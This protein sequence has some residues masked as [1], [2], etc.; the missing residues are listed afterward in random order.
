[1]VVR[2]SKFIPV[3][4]HHV[5]KKSNTF[6]KVCNTFSVFTTQSP[7]FYHNFIH[8]VFYIFFLMLHKFVLVFQDFL[9]NYKKL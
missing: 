6:Y 8:T 9:Y 3:I 7:V 5:S 4:F 1:M 2:A